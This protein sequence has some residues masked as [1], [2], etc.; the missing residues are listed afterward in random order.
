MNRKTDRKK[1]KAGHVMHISIITGCHYSQILVSKT[2]RVPNS[3]FGYTR[4]PCSK[5]FSHMSP[6]ESYRYQSVQAHGTEVPRPQYPPPGRVLRVRDVL[7]C[8]FFD[9]QAMHGYLMGAGI[10]APLIDDG[11]EDS[12]FQS[13]DCGTFATVHQKKR[14]KVV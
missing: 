2:T 5:R 14:W 8:L 1:P 4:D 11:G 13:W 3:R 7:G 6:D 10:M 12:R 9:M